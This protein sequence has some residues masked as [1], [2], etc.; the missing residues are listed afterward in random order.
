MGKDLQSQQG[1]I[2][3]GVLGFEEAEA[4]QRASW[5]P[6]SLSELESWQCMMH[7]A[8]LSLLLTHFNQCIPIRTIHEP[9]IGKAD[10]MTIQ[11]HLAISILYEYADKTYVQISL[12]IE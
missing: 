9:G 4:N 10:M 2:T 6:D 11:F 5:V 3:M 12:I 8:I 1:S 7:E